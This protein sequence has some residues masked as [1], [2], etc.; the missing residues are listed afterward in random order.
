MIQRKMFPSDK[1]LQRKLYWSMHSL[2]VSEW[3]AVVHLLGVI[4]P[5]GRMKKLSYTYQDLT[6]VH[7]V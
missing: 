1:I 5:E 7:Q 6:K 2:M 3:Q 4:N